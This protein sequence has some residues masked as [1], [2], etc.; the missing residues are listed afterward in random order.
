MLQDYIQWGSI[1]LGEKET[2]NYNGTSEKKGYNFL[3][4][5]Y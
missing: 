1:I 5:K 3:Y 2:V 4:K